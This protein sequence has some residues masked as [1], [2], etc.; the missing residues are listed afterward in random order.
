MISHDITH[1]ILRKCSFDYQSPLI[2]HTD[3]LNLRDS[4][5]GVDAERKIL[6]QSLEMINGRVAMLATV[7]FAIQEAYTGRVPV[8]CV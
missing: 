1:C 3:P 5:C 7:G 8:L 4:I 2:N 6:V